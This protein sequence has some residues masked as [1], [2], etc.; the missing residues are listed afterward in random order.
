MKNQLYFRL[1]R[2]LF[3][4]ITI[5]LLIL[6]C[7]LPL[8]NSE[9]DQQ[10]TPTEESAS[11]DTSEESSTVE[12]AS[13]ETPGVIEAPEPEP[14]STLRWIDS[15]LLVYIPPGEFIMGH[16][17]EDNPEHPVYLNGFWIYRTEVTNRMYLN[18]MARGRCSPPAVDPA[19]PDLED[20]ALADH[21][22][23]GIQWHQAVEYCESV[24]G[25]LPTE[26]QWEKTARGT[27][28]RLY[29]W[30]NDDPACELLNFDQCVEEITSV[31]DYPLGTSP[32]DVLDMAG[33]VFE[34]VSDWYREDYYTEAP[35]ENPMGPD[36][37]EERSVRGSTFRTEPDQVE[38]SHRYFLE[39]D[40]Y[41]TDLGFR[42]VVGNAHHYAPPCTILAHTPPD[43]GLGANPT[44]APDGSAS[45]IVDEPTLDFV[46]YCQNSLRG[47]NISWSPLDA[48]IN[49]SISA[50][51]ACSQYDADTLACIG[52]YEAMIDIQ[53]CKS[54]PP[55]VV[56]LG[57]LATCDP[58][59]VLDGT[60]ELCRYA[61]PPV[62]GGVL[63]APGYSLS[64]DDS[65]CV[66]E[67]GTP[68]DFPV[69]PV[70]GRFDPGL[71][72]IC[73]FTLPSTGDE[74][75]VSESIFF[76]WCAPDEPPPDPCAGYTN[77]N[78]CIGAGIGCD[79]SA[80]REVCFTP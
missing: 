52:P 37:G 35:A 29:P 50:G 65:C 49:Y 79:W 57:L 26:A 31:I 32:Y 70:G 10:P 13:T 8:L 1:V 14:G 9:S 56:E 48:D 11:Q 75:C 66:Q 39:P 6:A 69:C 19:I 36:F 44:E 67:D 71:P 55:P 59:Y 72:P 17:G 62:P 78:E 41:R 16:D 5:G 24:D 4:S 74:K 61:G 20:P 27:D 40:E 76:Q 25:A 58:P 3:G 42:C 64:G 23:V 63:C 45:C 68:L 33:N 53:A 15:S 18:C 43:G 2:I 22:V 47:V 73:W 30:G 28:A 80:D 54:C 77:P 34:W 60:T 7:S 21:P 46:T 38:S 51:A 12:D